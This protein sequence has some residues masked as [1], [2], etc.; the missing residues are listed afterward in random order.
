MLHGSR[1]RAAYHRAVERY[2]NRMRRFV[3]NAMW[4]FEEIKLCTEWRLA[5]VIALK[6]NEGLLIQQALANKRRRKNERKR[7]RG[8]SRT[9]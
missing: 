6:E 4:S 7:R 5:W 1:I 9:N 2:D 3:A 8:R